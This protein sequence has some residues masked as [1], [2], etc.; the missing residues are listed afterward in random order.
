MMQQSEDS[1]PLTPAVYHI[2]LA[3]YD[4]AKH[5]YAISQEVEAVTNGSIKMGSGT[6]YGSIKRML[7]DGLIEEAVELADGERRYYRLTPYGQNVTI[8][9][10]LRLARLVQIAQ[11]KHAL[12]EPKN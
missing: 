7:R 8:D 12:Q 9:E 3:L 1:L 2:L 10:S 5:G 6:L 4:G 11:N